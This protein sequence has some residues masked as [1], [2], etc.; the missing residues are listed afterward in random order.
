MISSR[1]RLTWRRPRTLQA[2]EAL[3]LAGGHFAR[4]ML[5]FDLGWSAAR[6]QALFELLQLFD[7][8]PHVR[9]ARDFV[10]GG[11]GL[12]NCAHVVLSVAHALVP[13]PVETSLDMARP[14]A[15]AT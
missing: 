3:R 1:V 10:G 7:K 13:T 8:Q 4:A 11:R 2:T 15:P 5:P 14:S 6:A 12:G 9:Y